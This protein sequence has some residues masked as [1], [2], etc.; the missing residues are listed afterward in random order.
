MNPSLLSP[1]LFVADEP[2]GLIG[3]HSDARLAK[4]GI[5]MIYRSNRLLKHRMVG[6]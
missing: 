4:R 2:K 6:R 5:E 1:R 3:D